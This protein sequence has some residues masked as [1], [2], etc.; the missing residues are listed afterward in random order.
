MQQMFDAPSQTPVSKFNV[1]AVG[2]LAYNI[3]FGQ[4]QGTI[5]QAGLSDVVKQVTSLGQAAGTNV[6]IWLPGAGNVA[7]VALFTLEASTV[8]PFQLRV[9]G[10]VVWDSLITLGVNNTIWN[11]WPGVFLYP[12]A[13][14]IDLHNGNAGATD[15]RVTLA[16]C[17]VLG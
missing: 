14:Q 17:E 10:V 13:T 6:N 15:I 12:V 4:R 9:N 3:L 1:N 8:G 5:Q 7:Q 2:K 16:G 11:F